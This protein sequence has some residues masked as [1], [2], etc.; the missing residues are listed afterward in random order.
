MPVSH[1]SSGLILDRSFVERTSL[2]E[3]ARFRMFP[4]G[5]FKTRSLDT[6]KN[7]KCKLDL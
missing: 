1:K 6:T 3:K 5:I 4:E 2:F 7:Q